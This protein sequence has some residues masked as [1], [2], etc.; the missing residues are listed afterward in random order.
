[1]NHYEIIYYNRNA[2]S[3]DGYDSVSN[4]K[5][6]NAKNKT[7]AKEKFRKKNKHARIT[8]INKIPLEI[9]HIYRH[10]VNADTQFAS[11]E[12]KYPTPFMVNVSVNNRDYRVYLNA[13]GDL[14]EG[15]MKTYFFIMMNGK[16]VRLK[17]TRPN[18][19]RIM[20]FYS[21]GGK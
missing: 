7:K 14:N 3:S 11:S 20:K 5:Y 18:K 15:G 4:T 8:A 13:E 12:K 10:Y 21:K 6:V 1:M 17:E 19:F 2:R 16:E 9:V